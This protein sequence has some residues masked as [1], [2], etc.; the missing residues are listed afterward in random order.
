LSRAGEH[1]GTRTLAAGAPRELKGDTAD[2]PPSRYLRARARSG[3][4]QCEPMAGRERV[5]LR[6]WGVLDTDKFGARHR[7]CIWEADS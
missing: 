3:E 2:D 1:A 4:P 6:T 5:D 7:L